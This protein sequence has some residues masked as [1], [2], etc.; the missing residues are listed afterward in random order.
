MKKIILCFMLLL[1]ACGQDYQLP[2]KCYGGARA[3]T[4]FL[5][6]HSFS[7]SSADM[8]AVMKKHGLSSHY[9]IDENGKAHQLIPVDNIGYHAGASYWRGESGLNKN[10]VGIEIYNSDMGQAPYNQK[11]IE[12]VIALSKHLIEKYNIDAKNI[13]GH[14]DIAPPFKPDPGKEFFWKTLSQNNI[15]IWFDL[16]NSNQM[17]GRGVKELLQIIG[18]DVRDEIASAR[19]FQMRFLPQQAQ[20]DSDL[21]EKEKKIFEARSSKAPVIPSLYSDDNDFMKDKKFLEV[22]R[23]VAFEYEKIH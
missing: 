3:D 2:E 8:I 9:L 18:Y 6:F 16:K 5:V 10:S 1:G 23:A 12:S 22:L 4:K 11:Q 15:G 20:Y 7:L 19:A 21:I 13:V 14:S 17:D